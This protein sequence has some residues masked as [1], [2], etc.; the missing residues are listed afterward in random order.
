MIAEHSG[1]QKGTDTV[2]AGITSAVGCSE[3]PKSFIKK[4]DHTYFGVVGYT[5]KE[6]QVKI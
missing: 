2:Q 4:K 5:N 6:F 3:K 1:V